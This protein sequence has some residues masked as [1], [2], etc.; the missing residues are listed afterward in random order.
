MFNSVRVRLT[1]WYV[2]LFGLLLAGFSIFVYLVLSQTLYARLDQSLLAAVQVV[3]A[4]FGSESAESEEGA[5]SAAAQA[6]TELRIPG[7]YLAIFEGEQL[8][9]SSFD[10]DRQITIPKELL[11]SAATSGQFTFWTLQ[12]YEEEGA[13]VV[14]MSA[15]TRG[16]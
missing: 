7:V 1:S 10:R 6:L 16:K 3:A 13:R 9:G 5:V 14:A 11:A 8:L 2:L 15:H 12:D 4:E